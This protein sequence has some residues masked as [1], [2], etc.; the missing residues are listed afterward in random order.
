M[1]HKSEEFS[2]P[3]PNYLHLLIT[4]DL[5]YATLL[6]WTILLA[7]IFT[8]YLTLQWFSDT[9]LILLLSRLR[10]MSLIYHI[11]LLVRSNIFLLPYILRS[12]LLWWPLS[13]SIFIPLPIS[14]TLTLK[15]RLILTFLQLA[16]DFF[17]LLSLVI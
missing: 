15:L 14:L 6:Q 8:T 17:Q 1:M 16:N 12:S 3:H 4:V 2:S 11:K 7:M 13:F 10:S 5:R 9:T